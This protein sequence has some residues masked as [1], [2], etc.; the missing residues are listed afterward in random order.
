MGILAVGDLSLWVAL[1]CNGD[2]RTFAL[3]WLLYSQLVC[4]VSLVEPYTQTG[5]FLYIL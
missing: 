5:P 3:D 4:F 2:Q 1:F